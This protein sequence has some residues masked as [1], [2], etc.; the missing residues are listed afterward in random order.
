VSSRAR[1]TVVVLLAACAAAAAAVGITLLQTHGEQRGTA[2]VT[3][4]RKGS[5]PLLIDLG[6]RSDP[7]AAA[8]RRAVTLYDH[9]QRS[10]AA[11]IFGRY[12]SLDARIGAA[13]SGWPD[14]S[15][16]RL[17]ELVASAP[18]SST[19]QLHLGLAYYWSGRTA[20]AVAAWRAAETAQPDTPASVH[21]SDLLHPGLPIPGLPPFTPSVGPPAALARLQP[22][23]ELAALARAA[24]RA[25]ARSKLLYGVALQRL[26]RRVSAERQFAAAARLAPK[27][28]E[29]RVAEAVGRFTK[30]N[31]ERAFSR[32]G[33]L[34]RVFPHAATVRFHLGILLI[35]LGDVGKARKELRLAHAEA[36]NSPIGREAKSFLSRLARIGTK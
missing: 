5:P 21:A 11:R 32:L 19:A 36:P 26:G 20:D 17:K 14:G 28:P 18:K 15:L 27:D 7:Q 9:G 30:A 13:F 24:R 2:G 35:W 6:L 4:P 33:P 3:K 29:A 22:A 25:S 8:L 23:D 16:D 34:V 31:P 12:A 1:V 10:A